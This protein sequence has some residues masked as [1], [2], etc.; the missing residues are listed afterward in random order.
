MTPVRTA[1]GQTS[2]TRQALLVLGGSLFIAAAAQVSVPMY[3]VP[4][5]LTTLAVLIVGLSYGA[6]LATL[7]LLAYLAQG[8]AGLP[9]FAG[10]M[11]GL[12]F[13]GPTAGFLAGFVFMAALVGMAAD[14]GL[15]RSVFGAALVCAAASAALYIPGAAWPMGLA[16][17]LGLE[18]GWV[19]LGANQV[20]QAFAA[21]FVLGD[22][23]KSVLAALIVTGAAAAWRA[24]KS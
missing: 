1:I 20:W 13:I 17:A 15:T 3:P 8:A 7:T 5:T 18:G 6:R 16:A 4:M 14:R 2:L 23:V 9:V 12:A 11:N 10:G 24:R 22:A 21:P 19:G